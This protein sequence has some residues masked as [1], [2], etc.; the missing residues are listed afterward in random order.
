MT[1]FE[2]ADRIGELIAGHDKFC[3]A[4]HHAIYFQPNKT[5]ALFCSDS[6][7]ILTGGLRIGFLPQDALKKGLT[8]QEYKQ[9]TIKILAILYETSRSK[10]TG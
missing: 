1:F 3:P 6:L 7:D 4:S 8:Q 5:L 9:F 10:K 2:I